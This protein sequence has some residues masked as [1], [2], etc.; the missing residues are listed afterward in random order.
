MI[1]W[2]IFYADGST[3]SWEDGPP[4]KA[5]RDY[6]EVIMQDEPFRNR[7]DLISGAGTTYQYY[8]WHG[9]RWI[10]HD[11]SGLEQYKSLFK[12]NPIILRGFYIEDEHFWGIHDRALDY[13]DW[14]GMET[15]LVRASQWPNVLPVEQTEALTGG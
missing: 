9:D 6:V 15:R 3:F 12:D 7:R 8:C 14:K 1:R 10:I 2:I 13:P 4:E 5:P 11:E